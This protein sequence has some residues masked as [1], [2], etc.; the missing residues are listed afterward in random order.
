MKLRC[1][2]HS[3]NR[4]DVLTMAGDVDMDGSD[5]L[6]RMTDALGAVG[7]SLRV[8]LSEVTFMDS[9]GAHFLVALRRRSEASGTSLV[10]V[11]MHSGPARMLRLLGLTGFRIE[12]PQPC[13]V[14]G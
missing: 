11:G 12:Q 10:L 7:R 1:T 14:D 9:T 8:D 3:Q 4:T 5:E 13:K 2:L 6:R